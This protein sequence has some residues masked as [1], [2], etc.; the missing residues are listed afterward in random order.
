[1]TAPAI[2][3]AYKRKHP[4]GIDSDWY[5]RRDRKK[6]CA[7]K[8][9]TE[10][11]VAARREQR[12]ATELDV[13]REPFPG[14]RDLEKAVDESRTHILALHDDWDDEGSPGYSEATFSRAADFL[15]LHAVLAA[16]LLSSRL[17]V[18][19]ISPAQNGSIDL[20]WRTADRSLL[21]NFPRNSVEPASYFG[22]ASTGDTNSG[23]IIGESTRP[24]L[25]AWLIQPEK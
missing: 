3:T 8:R 5:E 17:S 6:P 14:F 7:P 15:V 16:Q 25:I 1:M 4:L 2:P 20:Y 11:E 12:S 10:S 21:I 24:D 13:S 18:P 9:V 22:K 23:R 19:L